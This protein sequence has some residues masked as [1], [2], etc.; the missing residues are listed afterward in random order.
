MQRRELLTM[1]ATGATLAAIPTIAFG[2]D[3]AS[4]QPGPMPAHA[5]ARAAHNLRLMKDADG[6]FNRRDST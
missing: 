2:Q 4:D 3:A 1:A 5:S 6:A